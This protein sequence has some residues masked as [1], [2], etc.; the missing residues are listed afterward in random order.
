MAFVVVYDANV[1]Y[2]NALRDLLIRIAMAG[3]VQAKW[4]NKI[5]DEALSSLADKRP[6][7]PK[8]KLVRLRGLMNEAVPD[9][10]VDGYEPLI[11]GLKLPDPDD[12]HVLAAA[13]AVGAQVIVTSNL[14]DFPSDVLSPWNI[15]AKSPDDFL[16]DQIDLDDRIV[17]ACL[18]QI[19]DSHTNPPE[20]VEDVLDALDSAGLVEAVAALR[21]GGLDC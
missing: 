8:E 18:Q 4:T 5:L 6:D 21:A 13:I 15:E 2:G 14:A 11:E 7:I 17:W 9:C 10:L 3:L 19:A 20:T 12:R 16:L 1:L